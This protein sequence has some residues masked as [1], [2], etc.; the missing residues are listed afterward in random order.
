VAGVVAGLAGLLD[1]VL[2]LGTTPPRAA[3]VTLGLLM[4]LGG[5]APSVAA[6]GG[7]LPRPPVTAPSTTA[8]SGRAATAG[9]GRAPV[10]PVDADALF[11]AVSRT[12]DVL[13]GLLAGV[14]VAIA[15]AAVVL[16]VGGGWAGR[17]L[18]IAAACACALRARS[19]A[20]VWH[21]AAALI[22]AAL[23]AA[24]LLVVTMADGSVGLV[25]AAGLA[26]VGLF[27]ISVGTGDRGSPYLGRLADVVE[28]VSLA[29][30]VPLVCVTLGL[31]MRL[32]QLHL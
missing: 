19:Y 1:A 6:R 16:A 5:L 4:L 29:A 24:P 22:G 26:G 10:A 17:L 20:S 18:V 3:A 9:S 21:R 28:V 15:G 31:Y 32:R 14:A 11:R 30:I 13:A 23:T 27:T 25:V 12:D 8:A 7:G 2:L